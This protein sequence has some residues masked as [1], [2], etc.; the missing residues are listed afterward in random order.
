MKKLLILLLWL[1]VLFFSYGIIPTFMEEEDSTLFMFFLC[2]FYVF[3]LFH[4]SGNRSVSKPKWNK[5]WLMILVLSLFPCLWSYDH[6]VSLG[7]WNSQSS[8]E[9]LGFSIFFSSVRDLFMTSNF[10][11]KHGDA[12]IESIS[13]KN[14]L[15]LYQIYSIGFSVFIFYE[16]LKDT[17]N[18]N[19]KR[20]LAFYVSLI[21][22][23]YIFCFATVVCLGINSLFPISHL[24]IGNNSF[25]WWK[26][27]IYLIGYPVVLFLGYH[28]FKKNN[29]KPN[30]FFLLLLFIFPVISVS[31]DIVPYTNFFSDNLHNGREI[32]LE[33]WL[34]GLLNI[35][36]TTISDVF[37]SDFRGLAF[38]KVYSLFQ[39]ILVLSVFPSFFM[40]KEKSHA[41]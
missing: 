36:I 35:I 8:G 21:K 31:G 29:K 25:L 16:W 38:V 11:F 19:I 30:Y 5:Y 1:F 9:R 4:F 28:F 24:I 2:L 13:K 17:F 23:H 20:T 15:V 40:N 6:S 33:P 22:R 41:Q 12:L 10:F 39:V 7:I 26:T 32:A 18:Q 27:I 34:S 3:I 37:K 14:V